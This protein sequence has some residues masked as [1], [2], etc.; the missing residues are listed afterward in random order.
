LEVSWWAASLAVPQL[1]SE[2]SPRLRDGRDPDRGTVR[3]ASGP[4][5]LGESSDC[6]YRQH[7]SAA[8]RSRFSPQVFMTRN[9]WSGCNS[10]AVEVLPSPSGA[11][12]GAALAAE[13]AS[14][15]KGEA[16]LAEGTEGPPRGSEQPRRGAAVDR[17]SN[18]AA[19]CC[20]AA[21][22]LASP[23]PVASD[24]IVRVPASTAPAAAASAALSAGEGPAAAA[25][26][27]T[28]TIELKV[29][30]TPAPAASALNLAT[31][32]CLHP[33][34]AAGASSAALLPPAHR[35]VGSIRVEESDYVRCESAG[36]AAAPCPCG[37]TINICEP[38]A[39]SSS[40]AK[41]CEPGIGAGPDPV[42]TNRAMTRR[43]GRT[44]TLASSAMARRFT[45]QRLRQP[46]LQAAGNGVASS[47]GPARRL[48]RATWWS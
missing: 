17:R 39:E 12:V 13:L 22:A 28:G 32:P 35:V 1:Q 20:A 31:D 10:L 40:G 7:G 27:E 3:S 38:G 8:A 29:S 48:C 4:K 45:R 26:A 30:E 15:P 23:P 43:Q 34:V 2:L 42:P 11:A 46:R 14:R 37:A 6:C 21:A 36:Q 5:R 44:P 9:I 25:P 33:V 16:A 19:L 41:T 47:R 24:G 18:G